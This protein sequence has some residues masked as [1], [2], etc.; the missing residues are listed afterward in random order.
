M[1]LVFLWPFLTEEEATEIKRTRETKEISMR[2]AEKMLFEAG[3]IAAINKETMMSG[4]FE[5]INAIA[6]IEGES[7]DALLIGN[8][9]GGDMQN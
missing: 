4:V 9:K 7:E 2:A 8:E 3:L 5:N 6:F 1:E